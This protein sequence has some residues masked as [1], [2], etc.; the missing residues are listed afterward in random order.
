[1]QKDHIH[2]QDQD[3]P[4]IQALLK[5][6][7]MPQADAG[8][9]DQALARA[10][11]EGSRRQRNRWMITGFGGAIAAGLAVWL[12]SGM[13]MTTPQLPNVDS[14]SASIA[15][16][17]MTLEEP[18]TVNLVFSTAEAMESATLTVSLPAGVELAGFP[19][20]SEIS[21]ETSLNEGRNLLPLKL[22]ALT[23]VGGE[24]LARLEHDDRNRVFRLQVDVS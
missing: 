22:I 12:I 19:G 13:L 7:P 15:G 4:E 17:T 1:M 20:Q 16:V 24:L 23:P 18:R 10:T 21:W 11:H 9:Y 8:F 6:Y 3:D 14:A 2:E 5:D